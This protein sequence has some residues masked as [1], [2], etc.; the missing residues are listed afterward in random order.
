MRVPPRPAGLAGG[1]RGVEGVRVRRHHGCARQERGRR[2]PLDRGGAT[3]PPVADRRGHL[4]ADL[5]NLVN[6]PTILW[7]DARGRIARPNDVAFGTDT[8]KH[9]TGLESA[10][11]L[12][13]L[14]AWVRGE[15]APLDE[16]RVRALVPLPSPAGQQARAE[17]GLGR[18]LVE[19]GRAEAAERHFVRAG[20]LAP[21]DFTIRRGTMPMR[22]IDP[23]G[24]KFREM[25]QAWAASGN[26]YYR[27]L[28]E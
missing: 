18:W 1:L 15:A 23:M 24:P 21:H 2:A 3:D 22:G 26:P 10:K 27:P 14:R 6:V 8:F 7:I 4:L 19:R 16:A 13:A 5:Y 20:E 9:L 17:F 25:F 11:H 28:P 12:A